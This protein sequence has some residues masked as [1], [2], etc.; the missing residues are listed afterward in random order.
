MKISKN[1]VFLL[2]LAPWLTGATALGGG[3][4]IYKEFSFDSDSQAELVDYS[5]YEHFTSVDNVH[6][7]DGQTLRMTPGQEPIYIPAAGSGDG[8]AAGVTATIGVA[9]R[10]FPQF[11]GKLEG[12]RRAWEAVGKTTAAVQPRVTSAAA[13][14]AATPQPAVTADAAGDRPDEVLHTQ[15]GATYRDWKLTGVEADTVV[16]S[17]ADGI[18][19]VPMAELPKNLWGFPPEVVA[20]VEQLRQETAAEGQAVASTAARPAGSPRHRHM[21]PQDDY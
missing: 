11:A 4:V 5:S 14:L 10:R 9:E 17:H 3:V 20:R 6:T 2:A 1:A 12:Y 16:I 19:R 15:D 8:T 13:I 21:R 7:T 18:S